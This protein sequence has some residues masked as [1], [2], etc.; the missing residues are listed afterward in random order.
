MLML[1]LV[2]HLMSEGIQEAA[3]SCTPRVDVQARCIR[4]REVVALNEA[5]YCVRAITVGKSNPL[6]GTLK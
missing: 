2:Y 4:I 5:V 1:V 3:P 6:E